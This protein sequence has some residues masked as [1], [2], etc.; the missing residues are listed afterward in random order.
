MNNS[1]HSYDELLDLVLGQGSLPCGGDLSQGQQPSHQ[2]SRRSVLFGDLP[3]TSLETLGSNVCE[4][5]L[6]ENSEHKLEVLYGVD[7]RCAYSAPL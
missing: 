2:I 3:V 7:R 1:V 4:I 5:D 6:E